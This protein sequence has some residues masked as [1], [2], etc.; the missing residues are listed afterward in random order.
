M[1]IF[2]DDTK[3]KTAAKVAVFLTIDYAKIGIV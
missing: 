3:S 1:S 2:D